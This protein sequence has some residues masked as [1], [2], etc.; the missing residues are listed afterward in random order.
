MGQKLVIEIMDV[1]K[2]LAEEN[3][4]TLILEKRQGVIY[5]QDALDIT[6]KVVEKYNSQ[7]AK[8]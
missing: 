8:K 1:V 6:G 5:T 3:K 7:K 2:K 4:Y